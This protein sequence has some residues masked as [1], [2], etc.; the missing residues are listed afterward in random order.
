MVMVREI[1]N[2]PAR[3]S[4]SEVAQKDPKSTIVHGQDRLTVGK[5]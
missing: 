5:S 4:N 3:F 2:F 1:G